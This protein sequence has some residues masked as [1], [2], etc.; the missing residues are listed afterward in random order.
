M[1]NVGALQ[2]ELTKLLGTEIPFELK[3]IGGRVK[4]ARVAQALKTATE[5]FLVR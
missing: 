4:D 3:E 2:Q 5:Q 1:E